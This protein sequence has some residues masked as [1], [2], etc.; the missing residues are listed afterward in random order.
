MPEQHTAPQSVVDALRRWRVLAKSDDPVERA[1]GKA[2]LEAWKHAGQV[3]DDDD[4]ECS[5]APWAIQLGVLADGEPR[6]WRGTDQFKTGH[7]LMHPSSSGT[8]M[9]VDLHKGVWYCSSCHVGSDVIGW[10]AY[11]QGM[12][13]GAARLALLREYGQ[14]DAG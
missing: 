7:S 2:M 1:T 13:R 9:S 8:C 5:P 12:T 4:E 11:H 6:Q 10:V 3:R 14:P